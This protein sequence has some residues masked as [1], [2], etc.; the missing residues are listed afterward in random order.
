MKGTLD[1]PAGTPFKMPFFK[2]GMDP[3]LRAPITEALQLVD[4]FWDK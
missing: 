2:G 3:S 1:D 4:V